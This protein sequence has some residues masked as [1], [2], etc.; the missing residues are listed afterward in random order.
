MSAFIRL[1]SIED[2]AALAGDQIELVTVLY[3][4]SALDD[5]VGMRLE[6]ADQLLAGWHRLTT[7]DAALAMVGHAADEDNATWA[8]QRSAATPARPVSCL[9][10]RSS[11]ARVAWAATIS[12]R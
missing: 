11:A 6:Q 3:G 7:Q 12:L 5:D 8:R 4:A 10:A 2:Q 1:C 9:T